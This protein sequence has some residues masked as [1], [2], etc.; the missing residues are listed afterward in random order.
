[1]LLIAIL[2]VS[3]IVSQTVRSRMTRV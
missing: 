3:L 1:L 2:I